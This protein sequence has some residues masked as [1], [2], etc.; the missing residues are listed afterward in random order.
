LGRV[1][2]VPD[3]KY[4]CTPL[5]KKKSLID[6]GYEKSLIR[7]FPEMPFGLSGVEEV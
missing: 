2:T 3:P 1:G 6:L 5:A 4:L 7:K